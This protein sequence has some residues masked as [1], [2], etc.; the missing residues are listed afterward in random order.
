MGV[1]KL[2][3]SLA[4]PA[5]FIAMVRQFHDGM[6]PGVQ[7][8]GEYSEPFPV[9]KGVEQCC[10]LASALF[11]MMFS[12]KLTDAFQDCDDDFPIRYRF[13]GKLFNLQRLQAKSKVLTDVLDELLYADEM[14]KNASTERK[15]QDDIGRVSQ[16]CDNYDLKTSTNKN[17]VVYQPALGKL[18]SEPTITVNGQRLQVVD[19]FVYLGSTLS[20]AVH[21]DDEVTVRIA[22]VSVAFRRL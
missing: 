4:V 18:Y 13:V 2:W 11:S 10:V 7:N 9:T 6:L 16:A 8:D 22:K 12:A 5:R 3:Q 21:F 20:R 14:A 19:K 1:G 15:I 17:E